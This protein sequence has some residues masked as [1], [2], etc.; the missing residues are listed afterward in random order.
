M[1]EAKIVKTLVLLNETSAPPSSPVV[2]Y[3]P[4]DSG[5][6]RVTGYVEGDGANTVIVNFLDDSG[7][8]VAAYLTFGATFP[9]GPC[10]TCRQKAGQPITFQVEDAG[11]PYNF[12][13]YIIL[14]KLEL[15]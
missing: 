5:L 8:P 4:P 10:L 9:P 12:S 13:V 11:S 14:E 15:D 2:L 3:T 7:N 1:P 6:F